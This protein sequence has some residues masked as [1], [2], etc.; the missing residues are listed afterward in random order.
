MRSIT[1]GRGR[2]TTIADIYPLK[3]NTRVVIRPGTYNEQLILV[4]GCRFELEPGAVIDY[5]ADNYDPT[6][7]CQDKTVINCRIT[8]GEIRRSGPNPYPVAVKISH[9]SQVEL[10]STTVRGIGPA[11]LALSGTLIIKNVTAVSA[12]DYAI[13]I[14]GN[15][16]ANIVGTVKSAGNSALALYGGNMTFQGTATSEATSGTGFGFEMGGG[17]AILKDAHLE[18]MRNSG[19]EEGDAISK[20]GG[21][22]LTLDNCTLICYNNA[23]FSISEQGITQRV[24]LLTD[25][26]AN[27][28]A[29]SLIV[30]E[31]QGKLVVT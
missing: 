9:D 7:T 3:P 1:V 2:Y 4:S 8:G 29:S 15:A 28:P 19:K 20:Y 5:A 27:R 26:Y 11:I 14:S 24:T 31:G 23:A 10:L 12:K 17:V 6:V 18:S 16:T 25:C 30:L 21:E 13:W 22:M